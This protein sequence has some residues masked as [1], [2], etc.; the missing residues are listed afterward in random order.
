MPWDISMGDYNISPTL[1]PEGLEKTVDMIKAA[2]MK[3]GIWFEIDNI[4]CCK[5]FA[6]HPRLCRVW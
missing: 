3:P 6:C 2:G 4:V 5:C 1:F